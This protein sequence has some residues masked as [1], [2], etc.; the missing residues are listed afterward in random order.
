MKENA[1]CLRFIVTHVV[2][3]KSFII[4]LYFSGLHSNERLA[5]IKRRVCVFTI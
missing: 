5:Y 1:T 4:L 3:I 2:F